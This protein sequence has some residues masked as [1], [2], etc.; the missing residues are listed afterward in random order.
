M[1]LIII[2]NSKLARALKVDGIVLYPFIMFSSPIPNQILIN[3]ELV[4]VDQI[5]RVG[6]LRFYFTYLK[7]YTLHRWRGIP[8]HQ[9]Y[10]DIS[11]EKEAYEKQHK[12]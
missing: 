4:H 12:T 5:K 8:H 9:A 6:V 1:P 11:Y 2:K 10:M 3:H 7:E